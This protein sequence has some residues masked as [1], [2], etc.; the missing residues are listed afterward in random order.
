MLVWEKEEAEVPGEPVGREKDEDAFFF[1]FAL[2]YKPQS[3]I[4]P[5]KQVIDSW[6]A[7]TDARESTYLDSERIGTAAD[8]R[9]KPWWQCVI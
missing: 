2:L 8:Y 6:P 5:D 9:E 7:P 1:D 3:I 4:L